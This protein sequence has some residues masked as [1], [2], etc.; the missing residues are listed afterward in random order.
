MTGKWV[1]ARYRATL[2]EIQKRHVEWEITGPPE[3]RVGGDAMFQPFPMMTHAEMVRL[4][5][6]APTLDP[7]E[8]GLVRMF[9]RRYVAWCA[10]ARHH[11]RV[12]G[13]IALYRYLA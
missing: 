7:A 1:Y 6:R 13:A 11:D 9:L 10:R 4:T 12:P 3:Y 2:A 8:A 5:E